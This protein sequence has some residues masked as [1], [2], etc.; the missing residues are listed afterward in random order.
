M[1]K[2]L[3]MLV[4]D[5]GDG[6]YYIRYTMSQEWLDAYQ[7]RYNND[8]LDCFDLGV[9]GDGFH[10]QTILVPDDATYES[11]GISEWSVAEND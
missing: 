10:Y 5:C 6:S 2:K 11:L 7:E 8:E 9:D 4:Q 3:Y 1:T